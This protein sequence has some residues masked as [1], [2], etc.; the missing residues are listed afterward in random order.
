MIGR[1]LDQMRGSGF[2]EGSKLP[3]LTLRQVY[4]AERVAKGMARR[5][6]YEAIT[7]SPPSTTLIGALA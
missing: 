6:P 3:R 7:L 1:L 4:H 5:T 2:E